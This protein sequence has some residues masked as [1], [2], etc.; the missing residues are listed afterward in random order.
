ML[1]PSASLPDHLTNLN[2]NR[3]DV[4]WG[5]KGSDKE[6]ALPSLSSKK[7]KDDAPAVVEDTEKI[8]EDIDSAFKETV[9][10][11]VK[12]L[13]VKEEVEKP[14]MDVSVLV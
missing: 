6:E 9:E 12:K 1:S 5:T 4:S 13:E 11:A 10:R 8:Q 3:H 7:G 14:T 2:V